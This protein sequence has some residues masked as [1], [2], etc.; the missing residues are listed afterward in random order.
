MRRPAAFGPILLSGL[1]A[2]GLSGTV[3]AQD[4]GSLTVL[5]T[6]QEDWCVRMVQEF[7]DQTGIHTSYVRMSSGE[8]LARLRA[9]FRGAGVRCLVGWTGGRPDRRGR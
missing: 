6:P 3:V 9:G 7:Q 1:L 2:V 5:C 8:A 4:E